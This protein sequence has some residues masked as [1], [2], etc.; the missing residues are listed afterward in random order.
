MNKLMFAVLVAAAFA[1]AANAVPR[2]VVA[3]VPASERNH[4]L[5]SNAAVRAGLDFEVRKGKRIGKR[6]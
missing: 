5:M 4:S 6:V 1:A 2:V 3:E